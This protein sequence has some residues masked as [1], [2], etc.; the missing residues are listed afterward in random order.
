MAKNQVS[1]VD[2]EKAII[3]RWK[4]S[5]LLFV[6]ECIKAVPSNQ[7]EDALNLVGKLAISKL[8]YNLGHTCTEE[9]IRLAKKLGISIRSGRGT[10]KDCW[11]A[12][13]YLWM[14]IC[15][16]DSQGLVTAP[17]SHQLRDVLWKEISKWLKPNEFLS[18]FLQWQTERVFNKE[19]P[20]KW[21]ITAR[22]ANI[23]GSPEEQSETL[24]GMHS[25]YMILAGDEASGLPMGIFSNLE[26]T[27][28]QEMNFCILIS[29]G[30]R[31][32]GYFFNTHNSDSKRWITLQWNS[33]ESSNVTKE[34]VEGMAE[35]YGKDSNMYRINVLGEFPSLDSDAFIPYDW[36]VNSVERELIYTTDMPIIRA[37]DIGGG[38]DKSIMVERI[39]PVVT[40]IEEFD[41][42]RLNEVRDWIMRMLND[43]EYTRAYIDNIGIGANVYDEIVHTYGFKRVDTCDVREDSSD[44]TCF[45]LRDELWQKA[46][47]AFENGT[48]SIPDDEE[49]VGEL[50]TIRFD[51]EDSTKGLT[52]IESKKKLRERGLKS[53]NKADAL[54][55]TY[56]D[57]DVTYKN[58]KKE[59]WIKGK[60]N[61][62]IS[63]KVV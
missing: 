35:K 9:E 56:K 47:N 1:T 44:P 58:V 18:S 40:R 4:V 57:D 63:W 52:K 61:K 29:Q 6:K 15:F 16:P 26:A 45:R 30:S 49:L 55:M 22:T 17:T 38:K 33:E 62:N 7:Q 20:E 36:V 11:L 12:W 59:N 5:P 37:F 25:K 14:L 28:T 39:G 43:D 10:G 53:P 46:K 34:F 3:N 23:K 31:S 60:K 48:I 19:E 54:I 51:N 24:S 50:T 27:M 32:T 13:V 42:P 2:K 41:S 8:K 21:F